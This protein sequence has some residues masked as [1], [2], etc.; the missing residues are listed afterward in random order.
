MSD[1]KDA[2]L[3]AGEHLFAREGI[4]GARINELTELAGQRNQSALHYHFGSRE[5]LLEAIIE[6]HLSRVDG[7]R[8]R[9]LQVVGPGASLRQLVAVVVAPL[10][11][12]LATPSGRD[13]LRIIPQILRSNVNPPALMDTLKLAEPHLANLAEPVR[14]ERMRSMIQVVATLL[15]ARAIAIED[16]EEKFLDEP[17]FIRNLIEMST[18]IL[19]AAVSDLDEVTLGEVSAT[20]K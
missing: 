12:E 5:G 18:A 4:N 13:Y 1:T 16:A 3:R 6:R 10:A 20:S 14:H 15:A 17:A 11:E 2:L 7:A 9:L 8:A 19:Q